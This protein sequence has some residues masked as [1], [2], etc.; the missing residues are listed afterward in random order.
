MNAPPVRIAAEV[1]RLLRDRVTGPSRIPRT[2]ETITSGWLT[3]LIGHVVTSVEQV[4]ATRGTTARARLRLEGNGVPPSVFVKLAP[5]A[6][7]TRVFVD[8]NGLGLTEV[9][10][11]RRIRPGLSIAAPAVYGTSHDPS[12]GRFALVLEDLAMRGV[13]FGDVRRPADLA[14]ASA[15]VAALAHFHASFWESE[16]FGGNLSWIVSHV[17]D[18]NNAF[19]RPLVRIAFRRVSASQAHLI[20]SGAPSLI[21]RR[22]EIERALARGP[23]TLLHGD[24]HLGNLYFDGR[25]PGFLDWQVVRKGHALRDLAYFLVL[26][27][28][29]DLRRAHQMELVRD[30]VR[31]LAAR[32][33]ELPP[34]ENAW[35]RFRKE[36]FYP[37]IAAVVTSGLGGLQAQEIAAVGLARAAA[38]VEDLE[39]VR[40]LRDVL[41]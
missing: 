11:Y 2:L 6:L 23:I 10:F 40:A 18:P 33:V 27:L 20:P 32:G 16:R 19:V 26:S 1:V 34:F 21:A 29:T 4:E 41:A 30:Y 24:P 37:W 12:T 22:S 35:Q 15:V 39:T 9:R 14:E 5:A 7:A 38:A 36:A 31:E 28:D 25:T 3:R 17:T 8:V 13:R